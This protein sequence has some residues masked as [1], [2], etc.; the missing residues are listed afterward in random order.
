MLLKD[1]LRSILEISA[2]S[3]LYGRAADGKYI[4]AEYKKGEKTM[5]A[6]VRCQIAVQFLRKSLLVQARVNLDLRA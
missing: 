2:R 6:E 5:V 1:L 3:Y 4:I